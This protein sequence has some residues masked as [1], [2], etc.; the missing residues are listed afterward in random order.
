GPFRVV[1]RCKFHCSLGGTQGASMRHAFRVEHSE[2]S[3]PHDSPRA[4]GINRPRRRR[5]HAPIGLARHLVP[6]N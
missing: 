2:L 6:D 1:E 5:M 3:N 4:L